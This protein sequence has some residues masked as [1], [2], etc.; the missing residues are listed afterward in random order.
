MDGW[1]KH[2]EKEDKTT[3][4]VILSLNYD[5]VYETVDTTAQRLLVS[6]LA[7]RIVAV[8]LIKVFVFGVS[9]NTSEANGCAKWRGF[10][11]RIFFSC[12]PTKHQPLPGMRACFQREL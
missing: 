4:F 2:N 11:D 7:V 5:N 9:L 10:E 1:Q 12:F 6:L 3:G 8:N